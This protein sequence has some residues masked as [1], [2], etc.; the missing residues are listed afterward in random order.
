[1]EMAVSEFWSLYVGVEMLE[2]WCWS[3]G[4]DVINDGAE[5]LGSE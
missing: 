2:W 5:M 4:D 1:M 3:D